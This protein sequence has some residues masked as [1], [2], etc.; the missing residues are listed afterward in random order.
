MLK[1]TLWFTII[2][3]NILLLTSI[4]N[5]DD[6]TSLPK[7]YTLAIRENL[8]RQVGECTPAWGTFARLD[9]FHLKINI[10]IIRYQRWL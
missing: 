1:A 5:D 7:L 3:F 10:S 4:E 9:F 2:A 8:P 6:C